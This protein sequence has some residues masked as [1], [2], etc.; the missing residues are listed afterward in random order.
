MSSGRVEA[1]ANWTDEVRKIGAQVAQQQRTY[2]AVADALERLRPAREASADTA[3][4]AAFPPAARVPPSAVLCAAAY[5][6]PDRSSANS[7]SHPTPPA[8]SLPG[9]KTGPTAADGPDERGAALEAVSAVAEQD[10]QLARVLEEA[11]LLRGTQ[12]AGRGCA[13]K[14][15]APAAAV[16]RDARKNRLVAGGQGMPQPATTRPPMSAASA[17]RRISGTGGVPTARPEESLNV[18]GAGESDALDRILLQAREIAPLNEMKRSAGLDARTQRQ[19]FNAKE[20]VGMRASA[21]GPMAT[22]SRAPRGPLDTPASSGNMPSRQSSTLAAKT[23]AAPTIS[24]ATGRSQRAPAAPTHTH[25]HTSTTIERPQQG[26][27]N[28]RDRPMPTRRQPQTPSTS[29]CAAKNS[30]AAPQHAM[31][32]RVGRGAVASV[33]NAL[34]S[35]EAAVAAGVH[36]TA[37]EKEREQTREDA[38]SAHQLHQTERDTATSSAATLSTANFSTATLSTLPHSILPNSNTPTRSTSEIAAWTALVAGLLKG[39]DLEITARTNSGNA[40]FACVT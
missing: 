27:S 13:T 12:A 10:E 25:T 33:R 19:A 24:S 6:T 15:K 9:T 4:E 5:Q 31:P 7:A 16:P 39:A 18:L 8:R 20:P 3:P 26:R 30:S 40:S 38:A 35:A 29:A 1:I 32:E 34:L 14:P 17:A 21:R 23:A 2:A 36:S 37:Q 11:R 28:S 22:S